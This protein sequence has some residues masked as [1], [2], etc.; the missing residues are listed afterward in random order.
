MKIKKIVLLC[1]ALLVFLFLVFVYC[2]KKVH[3]KDE[4]ISSIVYENSR[5]GYYGDVDPSYYS[6]LFESINSSWAFTRLGIQKSWILYTLTITYE[7]GSVKTV[8]SMSTIS[9]IPFYVYKETFDFSQVEDMLV[10]SSI[11]YMPSVDLD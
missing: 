5:E 10:E 7:D 8:E 4:N 6:E 1:G 9:G 2:P 3:I 11:V